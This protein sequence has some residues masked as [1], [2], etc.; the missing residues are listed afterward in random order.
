VIFDPATHAVVFDL[1]GDPRY[2]LDAAKAE[3]RATRERLLHE[4]PRG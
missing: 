4:P 1:D 2:D 3:Q